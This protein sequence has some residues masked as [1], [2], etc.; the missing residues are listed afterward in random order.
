MM[1]A[2]TLQNNKDHSEAGGNDEDTCLYYRLLSVCDVVLGNVC[3]HD[4]GN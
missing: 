1:E 3:M 2:Q 4:K